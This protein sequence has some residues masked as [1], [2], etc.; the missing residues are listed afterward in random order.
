MLSEIIIH[1]DPYSR[2]PKMLLG[3]LK[4]DDLMFDVHAHL[5]NFRDV[6]NGFLGIRLPFR[7]RFLHRIEKIFHSII[8]KTDEDSFSNLAY[9]LHFFQNR[10][11]E[12][13]AEKFM[14][15]YPGSTLIFCS[16]MMDM[17]PGIKGKIADP[18]PIQMDKTKAVRD[19]YPGNILPFFAADPNN[20]DMKKLFEKAFSSKEKYQFFGVKIYPSLGYL[21]SNPELMDIYEICEKYKIPVTTHCSSAVVHASKRRMQNISGIHYSPDKGYYEGTVTKRFRRKNDYAVFFNHPRNWFP[22]LEKYP[23]LKLNLA[24]FGGGE[25]WDKFING[26]GDSW[27]ARIIDLMYRYDHVYSDFSYS[28]YNKEHVKH[29]RKILSDNKII[30]ERVLY[31]SDYYMIVKEGHFRSLKVNFTTT[32]GDEMMNKIALE[33]PKRFLFS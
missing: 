8:S 28:L 24:H 22:V 15:Y 23:D 13:I 25:E 5:F 9:F 6:P 18:Y 14:S 17:A 29:L 32:M 33:N 4:K 16:L 27:V 31:G 1:P 2:V 30:A 3:N 26:E 20:K 19:K 10:S 12:W 7:R 21:P 11:P